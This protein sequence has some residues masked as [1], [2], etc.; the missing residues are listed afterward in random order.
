MNNHVRPILL[1]GLCS[2]AWMACGDNKVDPCPDDDP[3]CVNAPECENGLTPDGDTC[4]DD[5]A[6]DD[7]ACQTISVCGDGVVQGFEECDDGND[8]PFDGC[9][10]CRLWEPATGEKLDLPATNEWTYYPIEGAL[11]RDGSQAGFSVS[12][13]ADL[14]KL[15]FFYEG[16]GACFEGFNCAANPPNIPE[17]AQ[18]PGPIGIFDRNQ[19]RNPFKDWTIVYLPYCSGDV[20]V[21]DAPH[22]D[23]FNGPKDQQFV[24]YNNMGLYLNRL[25][26]TFGAENVKH[27]VST[28]ISA[29]GL[30]SV[31]TAKRLARE[32]YEARVTVLDDGGPTLSTN[33]VTACLQEHWRDLYHLEKTVLPDCGAAC[34]KDSNFL[35]NI[36]R[37]LVI[38]NDRIDFALFSFIHDGTVRLLFTFGQDDCS[39]MPFYF[40]EEDV[41]EKGLLD[42][43]ESL[44]EASDRTATYY[45]PSDAHTCIQHGCF[46][47]MSVDGV[48]LPEWTEQVLNGQYTHV[49]FTD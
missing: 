24:G 48:G 17:G 33:V 35:E 2:I 42:F 1:F 19:E 40:I 49:G 25:V 28:G 6:D 43:R 39:M 10:E 15:V 41:F 38:S 11:C 21:G 23:I 20:F 29:G 5:C 14:T 46:Y 22:A 31:V 27:V 13:G 47:N 44:K 34:E 36:A 26:P 45:A 8:D 30:S 7:T 9:H 4:D 37:D 16:G 12:P 18:H 32:F 3:E